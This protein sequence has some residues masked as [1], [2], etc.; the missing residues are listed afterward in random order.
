M[1][2][3]VLTQR[4]MELVFIALFAYLRKIRKEKLGKAVDTAASKAKTSLPVT[5]K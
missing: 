3:Y 2:A 1:I 4:R 5:S